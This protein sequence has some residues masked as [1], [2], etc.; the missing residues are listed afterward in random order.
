MRIILY[1]VNGKFISMCKYNQLIKH[2][3]NNKYNISIKPPLN[4]LS[5]DNYWLSEFTQAYGCFHI[6]VVKSK[7]LKTGFIVKLERSL[8]Q[9][10]FLPLKLLI[11]NLKM[12]N[13]SQNSSG[14]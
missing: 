10:D 13:I 6:S 11:D 3:Y 9:K 14:I 5:L 12:G 8:K 7:T 1:L 4:R 2:S